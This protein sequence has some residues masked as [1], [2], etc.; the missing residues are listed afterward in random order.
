MS[1]HR[2]AALARKEFLQISRDPRSLFL[3]LLMPIVQ[4]AMFGYGASL[5]I[6]HVQVCTFDRDGS[7][8]SQ[9]LLKRF[10]ASEYFELVRRLDTYREVP[11]AVDA[12]ECKIAVVIPPDFSRRLQDGGGV[13][14][15]ALVDATDDNSANVAIGYARALVG[16]YSGE[17]EFQWLRR[18]GLAQQAVV[19]LKVE[20]RVWF[21]EDL[22]SKAFLV[23]GVV[24][25]VMALV[26]AL[27]SSLTISREWERGTME[28]LITTPVRPLEIMFGKLIPYFVVGL[29]DAALCATIAIYWFEVPFRGT[30]AALFFTTALFLVVVLGVGYI[31]S[32]TTKSQLG[33]SQL[34]MLVTMMPTSLLSGFTFPID[35]MPAAVRAL[36]YLVYGRYYVTILKAIFLKGSG[37][38]ELAGPIAAL[39]IYA[40]IITRFAT[41]AFRKTLD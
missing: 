14:V 16:A 28:Q 22:Q 32:V 5:D 20:S 12:G 7:Q 19:P 41:R 36:T 35:Q 9:A 15:Q 13:A 1:W 2:L 10:Q 38:G 33:A 23:P 24:A 26:G 34:A 30:L 29:L 21:N 8:D 27:M 40:L 11:A 31:F 25:L 6:K 17:I 39:V 18:Q 4:M 37:L 3:A